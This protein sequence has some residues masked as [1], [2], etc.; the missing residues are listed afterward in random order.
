MSDFKKT[1]VFDPRKSSEAGIMFS[2]F[3]IVN[4]SLFKL[5]VNDFAKGAVTA[6]F[7]AVA[8]TV[9]GIVTQAG[10]NVFAADWKAILNMA[11][12]AAVAAFLGYLGKNWVSDSQ[13]RVF[14]KIG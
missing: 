10:F 12:S 11:F 5:N 1:I 13:G 6:V 4:S 9:L 2:D 7:S 14:G 3:K 8:V